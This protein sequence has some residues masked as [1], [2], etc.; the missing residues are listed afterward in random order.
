MLYYNLTLNYT[1]SV[2]ANGALIDSKNKASLFSFQTTPPSQFVHRKS[3]APILTA[4]TA[5]SIT[6]GT[7]PFDE[8]FLKA[9]RLPAIGV[10]VPAIKIDTSPH[11][12]R[13]PQ[14][15]RHVIDARALTPP[16]TPS[17]G[18]V[19]FEGLERPDSGWRKQKNVVP[20]KNRTAL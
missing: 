17:S 14:K 1:T 5:G 7:N 15:E 19:S 2:S 18:M 9:S 20:K 11:P 10:P 16:E 6:G 12:R 13:D 4:E 3:T 8:H